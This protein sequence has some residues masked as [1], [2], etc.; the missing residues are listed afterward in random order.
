MNA[1]QTLIKDRFPDIG[2][3]NCVSYGQHLK[4][5]KCD[6]SKWLQIINTEKNHWVLLAKGFLATEDVMIYDSLHFDANNSDHVIANICSIV[7]TPNPTIEYLVKSCQRQGNGYDCGA[8]AIAFAVS[9]AFGENPS[10]LVY[11][12][13]KLRDH[14]KISF[15]SNTLKPFPSTASRSKRLETTRFSQDV[16]CYCRQIDYVPI[17]QKSLD[18]IYCDSCN[19]SYHQKCVS[20]LPKTKRSK[21]YCEKPGCRQPVKQKGK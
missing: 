13:A 20:T 6:S 16:Y 12:P 9:L 8:F 7:E 15:S 11:D 2:A 4:F 19:E 10:Q 21:W 18:W 5:P 3:L 17:G 1:A 14:L